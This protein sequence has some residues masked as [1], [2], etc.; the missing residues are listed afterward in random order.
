MILRTNQFCQRRVLQERRFAQFGR[1]SVPVDIRRRSMVRSLEIQVNF[2]GWI[3]KADAKNKVANYRLLMSCYITDPFRNLSQKLLRAVPLPAILK[4]DVVNHYMKN[5]SCLVLASDHGLLEIMDFKNSMLRLDTSKC[6]N[7]LDIGLIAAFRLNCDHYI[8]STTDPSCFVN[9]WK[10]AKD[11]TDNRHIPIM[12]FTVN[13]QSQI[14]SLLNHT[15]AS[16]ILD[17]VVAEIKQENDTEWP[18]TLYTNIL[19]VTNGCLTNDS[20][21]AEIERWN[22]TN[23][24]KDAIRLTTFTYLPYSNVDPLDGTEIRVV[25]EFCRIYNCS[26]TI[27]ANDGNL[28]G[29]VEGDGKGEGLFGAVYLS[30]ADIGAAAVAPY[31]QYFRYLDYSLPYT[32][33]TATVLVPGPKPLSGWK[34]PF[35]PFGL[36]MWGAFVLSLVANALFLHLITAATIKF[37]RFAEEV[38]KRG[39]YINVSDSILRSIGT[40]VLQQTST[41]ITGTP[42]RH[43]ITSFQ[44]LFLI[45]TTCYSAE[46]SS[47]LTVPQFTKPISNVHELAASG[48]HWVADDE[49][50]VLPV[51]DAEDLDM[52]TVV[53]NF[54]VTN[55]QR[56]IEIAPTGKFAV[57]IESISSGYFTEQTHITDEVVS[58]LQ[59]MEEGIFYTPIIM[60]F[61]K[62]SPYGEKLNRLMLQLLDSGILLF[63]GGEVSRRFL[64]FRSGL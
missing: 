11:L 1:P 16:A 64:T 54:E 19:D 33:S 14:G 9:I 43:L 32:Y 2:A 48:L 47:Y 36:T 41:L 27:I 38:L 60:V 8:I 22:F 53:K 30:L 34:V 61:Q 49:V 4:M 62:A 31:I 56:L 29:T 10:K 51:K 12:F 58:K 18:V 24:F 46:L 39:E 21:V 13:H 57:A 3:V 50:W 7:G 52:Q 63:W 25:K 20:R 5:A 15:A 59:V 37:T 28:W 42:M 44:F 55:E 45:L 40:S 17:A 35:Q 23:G 6:P 26:I